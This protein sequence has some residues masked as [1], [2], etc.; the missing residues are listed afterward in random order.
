MEYD[1]IIKYE[2]D[3]HQGDDGGIKHL[4]NVGKLLPYYTAQHPRRQSLHTR[5]HDNL[6][7]HKLN[8]NYLIEYASVNRLFLFNPS[9]HWLAYIFKTDRDHCSNR[10]VSTHPLTYDK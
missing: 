8:M 3:C 4:W 7:S 10:S 5:R 9:I 6:K 1:L 2:D